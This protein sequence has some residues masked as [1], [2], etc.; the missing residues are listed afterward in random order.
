MTAPQIYTPLQSSRNQIRLLILLPGSGTIECLLRIV[1]LDEALQ[2]E[3]LSYVWGDTTVQKE[4]RVNGLLML[5]KPNLHDALVQF[6]DAE[7]DVILWVDA[8][9]VNQKDLLERGQQVALMRTV[10]SQASGTKVWIGKESSESGMAMDL[11]SVLNDAYYKRYSYLHNPSPSNPVNSNLETRLLSWDVLDELT[12]LRAFVLRPWFYRVW[13]IQEVAVSQKVTLYCGMRSCDWNMLN[14]GLDELGHH[15]YEPPFV[16][17][18]T[19]VGRHDLYSG[20][21][22]CIAI[23]RT[24]K[25]NIVRNRQQRPSLLSVLTTHRSSLATDPRDKFIALAGLSGKSVNAD[26]YYLSTVDNCYLRAAELFSQEAS[27]PLNFLDSV[28]QSQLESSTL[29]SWVPDWRVGNLKPLPLLSSR[30]LDPSAPDFSDQ[31][32]ITFKASSHAQPYFQFLPER[33]CLSA[34]GLL[35]DTVETVTTTAHHNRRSHRRRSHSILGEDNA[36]QSFLLADMAELA[37]IAFQVFCTGRNYYTLATVPQ[38]WIRYFPLLFLD[39]G[40]TQ[41]LYESYYTE[42]L[43][44]NDSFRIRGKKL[45]DVLMAHARKD[46][47]DV[48]LDPTEE[49]LLHDSVH[50]GLQKRRL[51]ETKSGHLGICAKV[52]KGDIVAILFGC[53]VPVV[54]R[55]QRDHYKF[56]GTCYLSGFMHGEAIGRHESWELQKQHFEIL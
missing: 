14:N 33:R 35:I 26:Q 17:L 43:Q 28:G 12:A 18:L 50:Q 53:D 16:E 22:R 54:L 19:A 49:S 27:S 13:V 45:R 4:I 7:R 15:R 52:R 31:D 9:C 38:H 34:F 1:S 24:R 23:N 41:L 32:W 39:T 21:E 10:Y 44:E 6:R 11:I 51:F 46:T 55:P 56:I 36:E 47:P 8:I 3:A 37:A 40:S 2:Y 20:I 30:Q 48:L 5:I 29:P 42:W 25:E